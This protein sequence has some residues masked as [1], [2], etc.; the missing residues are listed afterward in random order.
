MVSRHAAKFD[1]QRQCGKGDIVVLVFNVILQ[2]Y[3]IK[4][5]CQFMSEIPSQ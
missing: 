1:G 3:M 4:K 5:P 2:D